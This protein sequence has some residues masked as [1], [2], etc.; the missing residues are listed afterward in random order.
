[1]SVR[2]SAVVILLESFWFQLVV[3]AVLIGIATF[4]GGRFAFSY[5]QS[6]NMLIDPGAFG[7]AGQTRR[8]LTVGLVLTLM[9]MLVFGG[10]ISILSNQL[11][12]VEEYLRLQQVHELLTESFETHPDLY[13]RRLLEEEQL[14]A[15]SRWYDADILELELGMPRRDITMAVA[16]HGGFRLRKLPPIRSQAPTGTIILEETVENQSYGTRIQREGRLLFVATQSA[17][18]AGIGHFTRTL[19][20]SFDS[21]ILSN[22]RYTLSHPLRDRHVRFSTHEAW[23]DPTAVVPEALEDFRADTLDMASDV[24]MMVYVST[25]NG[26]GGEN[27]VHLMCGRNDAELQADL[28]TGCPSIPGFDALVSDLRTRL[29]PDGLHVGTTEELRMDRRDHVTNFVRRQTGLP[30]LTVFVSIE[31]LWGDD[32]LPYYKTL[33]AIRDALAAMPVAVPA[34]MTGSP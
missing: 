31:I 23:L 9:G 20:Q 15:R 33:A 10:L 5:R 26:R 14:S 12:A 2:G 7:E 6:F 16:A 30:V 8:E 28:S 27:D 3:L 4:I 13:T 24:D 29:A 19:A 34:T 18:D 22:E 1:M 25:S 21:S 11:N 32:E 17:T